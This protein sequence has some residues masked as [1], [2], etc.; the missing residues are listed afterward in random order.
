M[1]VYQYIAEN[2]PDAAYGVCQQYGYYNI[3]DLSQL[4]QCLEIIVGQNGEEGLSKVM[5]LHP[6]KDT[7]LE[8]FKKKQD[9]IVEVVIPTQTPQE[10]APPQSEPIT[11]LSSQDNM[12]NADGNSMLV[13]KTNLYILLG[14]SLVAFAII[15]SRNKS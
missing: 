15:F 12:K 8:L 10:I 6:D 2:N 5:E 14:A 13:N 7:L 11:Q 4:A 3:N 1:T 9:D